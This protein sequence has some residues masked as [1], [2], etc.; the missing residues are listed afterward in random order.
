MA[1]E[2]AFENGR[3]FN[4]EEL[5]TLTW[6]W[7]WSYCIPSCITHHPLPACQIS[8]S[9]KLFV[10]GRT[11][12]WT[13]ET[14]FI[15]ST[16]KS[17]PNNKRFAGRRSTKRPGAPHKSYEWVRLQSSEHTL[18]PFLPRDAMI[19]RYTLSSCVGLTVCLSQ[20]G[21]VP[22]RLNVGSLKQRHTI[23]Q[24]L[25]FWRQKFQRNS[26]GGILYGAP[27]TDGVGSNWR[28]MTNISLYLRNGG[29]GT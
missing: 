7:I 15:G 17:R 11:D 19:V 14:H 1:E 21:T 24:R 5:V 18:E 26:N 27:N 4:L 23:A 8:L 3:I 22:K 25:V 9:K 28:F 2:I 13:F 20:A 6:P 10:D 29:R 12:G 16:Q